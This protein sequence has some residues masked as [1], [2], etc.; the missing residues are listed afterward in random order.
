MSEHGFNRHSLDST[1]ARLEEK[2]DTVLKGYA[3][4]NRRLTVLEVAE[5]KRI[6]ALVAI[7]TICS[8][9]GGGMV[10]VIDLFKSR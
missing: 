8:A 7:G 10:L 5:N 2:L 1:L 9:I 4:Q 3:D 6:G